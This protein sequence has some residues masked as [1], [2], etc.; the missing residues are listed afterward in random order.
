MNG[1]ARC[2]WSGRAKTGRF[3]QLGTEPKSGLVGL[4]LERQGVLLGCRCMAVSL[5]PHN[6]R[7][8]AIGPGS[9]MTEVLQQVAS[10]KAAMNRCSIPLFSLCPCAAHL[11]RSVLQCQN[12]SVWLRLVL[13]V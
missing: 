9:I 13:L 3:R 8:N 1:S 7:V 12:T 6:I 11:S 4:C 5:A 2:P 10:D